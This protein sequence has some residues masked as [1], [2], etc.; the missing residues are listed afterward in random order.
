MPESIIASVKSTIDA[1]QS[2]IYTIGGYV[3]ALAAGV[4]V[5]KWIKAQFF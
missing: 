2:D 1:G 4:M 3:I 5:I